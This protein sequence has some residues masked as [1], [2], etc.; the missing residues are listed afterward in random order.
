[1]NNYIEDEYL[2]PFQDWKANQTPEGNA[3]ALKHMHP[4]IEG[5]VRAH[6]GASN[7]LIMS[8]AR[9]MALGALRTYDPKRSGLQTHLFNQLQGLKR[10]NRQQSTIIR[11]PERV[12]LDRYHL[13]QHTQELTDKLGR[14]PSDAELANHTGLS[15]RRLAR[16]RS[17]TP[18]VAEGALEASNPESTIFGS[19]TGAGRP[20]MSAWHSMVY[21]DLA[22]M[23]QVIMEHVLGL[24]NKQRLSNQGLAAKLKRSPGLISQRK[25][26]IQGMLDKEQDLSPFV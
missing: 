19:V 22:P 3:Q 18:A 15:A 9:R 11:A 12:A 21:D 26:I 6:V 25:K 13:E 20:A 7:P 5:A 10:V 23:D 17:Y 1:M 2:K 8:Q 24:N 16:A 4:L 14:S